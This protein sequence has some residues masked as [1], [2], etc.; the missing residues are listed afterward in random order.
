MFTLPT[1]CSLACTLP[2]AYSCAHRSAS[3]S[4]CAW[5]A[6]QQMMRVVCTGH[7]CME[8]GACRPLRVVP[9]GYGVQSA[10]RPQSC[11]ASGRGWS[12]GGGACLPAVPPFP[13]PQCTCQPPPLRP[14]GHNTPA[15]YPGPN[16]PSFPLPPPHPLAPGQVPYEEGYVKLRGFP[17]HLTK[18]DIIGFFKVRLG[19]RPGAEAGEAGAGGSR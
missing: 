14:R 16:N 3:D 15:P 9:R 8:H 1:A 18:Q 2:A 11:K 17:K 19:Q 7:V 6:W 5:C 4:P 13:E 12:P 10:V